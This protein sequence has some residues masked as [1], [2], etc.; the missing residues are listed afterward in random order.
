MYH[1]TGSSTII[2][3]NPGTYNYCKD[4]NDCI[5]FKSNDIKVEAVP[6]LIVNLDVEMQNKLYRR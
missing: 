1:C 5:A 6:T 4:A 3:V 2:T